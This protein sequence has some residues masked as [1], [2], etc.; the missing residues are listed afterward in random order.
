MYGSCWTSCSCLL[1][2]SYI[3]IE[4]RW[5]TYTLLFLRLC[6]DPTTEFSLKWQLPTFVQYSLSSKCQASSHWQ[7]ETLHFLR[8][9]VNKAAD[10]HRLVFFLLRAKDEH[11]PLPLAPLNTARGP[12]GALQAPQWVLKQRPND[13][14][15][16]SWQQFLSIFPRTN[17][18]FCTKTSLI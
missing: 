15:H 10:R 7:P 14:V 2:Y 11:P 1:E 18:I 12:G 13:L 8:R 6:T 16:T 4:T 5:F 3:S 17:I 9:S